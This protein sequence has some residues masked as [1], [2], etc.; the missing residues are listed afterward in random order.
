MV[1]SILVRHSIL[2][3]SLQRLSERLFPLGNKENVAHSYQIRKKKELVKEG[4]D[5]IITGKEVKTVFAFLPPHPPPRHTYFYMHTYMQALL[6]ISTVLQHGLLN[7]K[8]PHPIF[9]YGTISCLKERWKLLLGRYILRISCN[10]ELATVKM[11]YF[12][13]PLLLIYQKYFVL[14]LIFS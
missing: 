1:R 13:L 6:N 14:C 11:N 9:H 7:T 2:D 12:T 5:A 3:T 10:T 4:P 8:I